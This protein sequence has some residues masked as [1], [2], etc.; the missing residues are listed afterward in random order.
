MNIKL[1]TA[2]LLAAMTLTAC[3]SA[4]DEAVVENVEQTQVGFSLVGEFEV[5]DCALTRAVTPEYYYI[6]VS[7]DA[8]SEGTIST[9]YAGYFTSLSGVSLTLPKGEYTFYISAF[10]STGYTIDWA[11]DYS[12]LTAGE[13]TAVT[14][15]IAY[16]PCFTDQKV[17]RYYGKTTETINKNTTVTVDGKRFAYGIKVDIAAPLEGKVVLSSESPAFSYTV[18]STDATKTEQNIFCLAGEDPATS[19]KSTTITM[20]LYDASDNIVATTTKTLT[21]ARNHSKTLKVKALDPKANF[22]FNVD[23][24]DMTDDGEEDLS[25][26]EKEE[27]SE[28]LINGHAYVDLGITS[29]GKKLLWATT[30][31]GA[32]NAWDCGSYFAWG[33]TTAKS[34]YSWSTY[35]HCNGTSS[36]ITKYCN[37]SN[38][39]YNGYSDTKTVL[40]AAD[41]AATA[42]WGGPWRMPTYEQQIYLRSQCYWQWV[43]SYNGH[44]VKG[45]VVYKAKADADKG[46]YSFNNP[47]LSST[48]STSSDVHIFL[49]ASGYINGSSASNE[50][51]N[52]YY[53]SSCL[54]DDSSLPSFAWGLFF[55][56]SQVTAPYGS[57]PRYCGR[58][59]RPVFLS[60]E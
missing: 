5:Q 47:S 38:Y 44:D 11:T 10:K 12:S 8:P 7:A 55:G 18:K 20:N 36:T 13:F 57:Y 16:A 33:E 56:S 4:A 3:Q 27:T 1:S 26:E 50:G 23:D 54:Y 28:Q 49:P 46:K 35:K 17:D 59:V 53:W 52:G 6:A 29:W 51:S 45:F 34:V 15:P 30:N 42:N 48:Y 32:E 19:S 43:S 39:G 41:D 22:V 60:S 40:E 25:P 58:T 31:V 37:S 14:S 9:G 21:I 24:D 2:A